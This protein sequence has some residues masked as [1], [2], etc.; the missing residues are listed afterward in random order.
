M[1]KRQRAKDSL[2]HPRTL[3]EIQGMDE[4]LP[5]MDYDNVIVPNGEG[6]LVTLKGEISQKQ[7]NYINQIA[8]R[9]MSGDEINLSEV[10]SIDEVLGFDRCYIPK[11]RSDIENSPN[12][13]E[14]RRGIVKRLL[15]QL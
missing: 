11:S 3:S 4:Y 2:L 12:R 5:I 6:R 7:Q 1:K 8:N 10:D 13:N 15:K 14:M 9:F